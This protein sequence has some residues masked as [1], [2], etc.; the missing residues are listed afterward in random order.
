M[1]RL[2]YAPL[3]YFLLAKKCDGLPKRIGGMD[4]PYPFDCGANYNKSKLFLK[5]K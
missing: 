2:I 1:S 5:I 4:G 3:A